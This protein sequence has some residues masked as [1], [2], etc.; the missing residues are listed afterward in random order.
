MPQESGTPTILVADDEPEV[1]DLVRTLLEWQ[2]YSVLVAADGREALV[3]ARRGLPDLILLDVRMP[4]LSGLSVLD[5][6]HDDPRTAGIPV[7]MLS[8]VTSFSD[9]RAALQ[10]GAVAYLSKPFELKE[11]LDL[12][13][14]V[15]TTDPLARQALRDAALRNVGK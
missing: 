12:V 14:R 9:V 7:I 2:R 10:R 6:L 8:V 15:L 13:Q 3:H 11:M 5:R 1:V 4:G